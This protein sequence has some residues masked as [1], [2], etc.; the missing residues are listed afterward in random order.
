[1][2]RPPNASRGHGGDC[3]GWPASSS[4]VMAE[5]IRPATAIRPAHWGSRDVLTADDP[6][7]AATDPAAWV[8][9]CCHTA[10]VWRMRPGLPAPA[11][12][13]VATV[14]HAMK[15]RLIARLLPQRPLLLSRIL[16]GHIS[17][18][19]ANG[20]WLS[21]SAVRGDALP[22]SAAADPGYLASLPDVADHRTPPP[23]PRRARRPGGHLAGWHFA[24]GAARPMAPRRGKPCRL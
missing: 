13:W 12:A 19:M 3:K 17:P 23:R 24:R 21:R 5:P 7:R 4:R 11:E 10:G 14:L 18:K 6:C 16:R 8:G 2:T 20:F 22:A 1:M 9:D 15:A